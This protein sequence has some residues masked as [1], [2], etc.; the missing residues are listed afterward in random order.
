MLKQTIV[1]LGVTDCRRQRPRQN[2]GDDDETRLR[3][4]HAH[5]LCGSQ[6][7][8]PVRGPMNSAAVC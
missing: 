1:A 4:Q 6:S 2:A 3:E 5:T 7:L 8:Q